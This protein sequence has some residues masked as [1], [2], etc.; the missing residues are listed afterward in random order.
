[1][2]TTIITTKVGLN[3]ET[4]RIWL[5]GRLL[6]R[7]GFRVDTRIERAFQN[8]KLVLNVRRDGKHKVSK[9]GGGIPLIDIQNL[10]LEQVFGVGTKVKAVIRA[11]KVVI[12]KAAQ[13]LRTIAREQR[14]LDK[15][16][17]GEALTTASLF[18]GG[19]VLSKALHQGLA[20]RGIHSTIR[21]AAEREVKYLDASLAANPELFDQR[22][23]LLAGDIEDVD[24]PADANVDGMEAGIPCTGTSTSG[25]A[26]KHTRHAEDHEEAGTMFYYTLRWIEALQPALV[27]LENVKQYLNTASWSVIASMLQKLEYD[28]CVMVL[29]GCDFGALENR[30]R[31]VVVAVSTG[32]AEQVLGDFDPEQP[33]AGLSPAAER[34]ASVERILE[35]I[36]PDSEL[37][38][39]YDYLVEKE[40]R[41]IA[42]GK[43]FRRQI[44]HG[45]S[46]S[47]PTITREYQKARSTDPFLAHPTDPDLTRLFTP[48][49]HA[50]IK[51]IPDGFVEAMGV[52]KTT[53]NEILG[54]SVIFPVF[55][56]VGCSLAAGLN[57]LR[58][59][60]HQTHAPVP[61]QTLAAA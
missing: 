49:E 60:M 21:V 53:A 51:A 58:E 40:Q 9:K 61:E 6:E 12:R 55:R 4:P 19:G 16:H 7:G 50:R 2:T 17:R 29:N 43:N 35:P 13:K 59:A 52:A 8:G 27:T 20:D 54:Q 47:V 1:M 38:G 33:M 10:E 41:D 39:R 15:L 28:L 22:T 32:I 44:V 26:K 45:D 14:L 34:P 11:G 31:M 42:A 36:G 5:Q 3:K 24:P 46:T 18:H 25:R 37:W 56:A 57:R 48:T 23:A 30:D